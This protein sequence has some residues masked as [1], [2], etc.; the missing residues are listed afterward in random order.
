MRKRS[1]GWFKV[2]GL[3][4]VVTLVLVGCGNKSASDSKVAKQ[5]LVVATSGTLYP[6]SYHDDK[7]QKLTGFDVE[8]VKAVAKKLTAKS[9]LR[10]SMLTG[11]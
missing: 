11:N 2:F 1:L 3:L 7:N 6:T 10:N 4:A 5:P 9:R 8:I